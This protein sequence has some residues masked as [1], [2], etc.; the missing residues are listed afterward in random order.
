[1]VYHFQREKHKWVLPVMTDMPVVDDLFAVVT[2]TFF[3]GQYL[4]LRLC[5]LLQSGRDGQK[6]CLSIGTGHRHSLST[7]DLLPVQRIIVTNSIV[8]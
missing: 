2:G 1:M 6:L 8:D 4:G 3:N 7:F 5:F